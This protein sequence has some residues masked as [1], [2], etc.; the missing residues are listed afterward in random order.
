M[1]KAQALRYAHLAR[2]FGHGDFLDKLL[3]LEKTLHTWFEH[4]CNGVI[5]REGENGDGRPF[6]YDP[7]TGGR[8]HYTSDREAGARKRLD[9]LLKG[10][11]WKA[12]IQGDPRG[13]ALYIYTQKALRAYNKRCGVEMGPS[14]RAGGIDSCYSTV[15]HAICL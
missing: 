15:A 12:Y 14:G 3:R 13:C 6:W 10:T 5:Q 11:K 7:Q 8:G 1:T 4:E 9:A 2:I